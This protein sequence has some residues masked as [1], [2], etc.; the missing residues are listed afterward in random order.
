[1]AAHCNTGEALR[2][3]K[4]FAEAIDAFELGLALD[5]ND[6]ACKQGMQRTQVLYNTHYYMC[7]YL[8]TSQGWGIYIFNSNNKNCNN[9]N[10]NNNI[11]HTYIIVNI[12]VYIIL[13]V[14]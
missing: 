13:T 5:P 6:E 7:T 4:Q 2:V 8:Y 1:M 11:I 9:N 10:Y 3:S 12:N 14:I